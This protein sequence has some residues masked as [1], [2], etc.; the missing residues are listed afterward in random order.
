M[1]RGVSIGEAPLRQSRLLSLIE[2]ATNVIVV[3][4]L[5]VLT[6]ILVFPWFGIEA[7]LGDHLAIGLVFLVVSLIRSY[8]LRR[9][10]EAHLKT[11]FV[12]R[13]SV[14]HT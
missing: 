10:F 11:R 7:R 3:Y 1:N 4:G 5:A 14:T 12:P 6:Q 8:C 9:L 2:A 13:N